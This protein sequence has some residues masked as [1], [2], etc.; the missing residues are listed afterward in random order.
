MKRL[1]LLAHPG[2][3]RAVGFAAAWRA[4][5][6]GEA[7]A[8]SWEQALAPGFDLGAEL[9]SAGSE[10]LRIETPAEHPEIERLLL[11]RGAA[12]A[13]AEGTDSQGVLTET[14]ARELP[15][16]DGRLRYQRQWYLGWRRALMEIAGACRVTGVKAMNDPAEIAVL[17]DK[18]A[19]R[20]ILFERGVPVPAAAGLA[21]GFDDL[22]AK[23]DAA[24][25]NRVFLKPCHGSSAAGV[26]A[27]SRRPGGGDWSAFTSAT[28]KDGGAIHNSKRP[29]RLARAAEIRATVDAVCRERALVERWFPKA[30]LG[31]RAFDLRILVIAGQAA[32]V[33]VRTSAS[34]ITNLHL[35]NRRGDLG[36]TRRAVGEKIWGEAMATAAAAAHGFPGCHYVGVDLMIGV[37]RRS[38]A[39]AEVNAF[40]D[41]LRRELWQGMN[42]WEA[43]VFRWR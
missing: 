19:T 33:A 11:A 30:T 24:G 34:P 43:E 29:R 18:L 4:A 7:H 21:L 22:V 37:A 28:L 9:D 6:H 5:G 35:R 31:G 1:A 3:R 36:E 14:A 10:V 8:I 26:M 27:I 41:D 2:S 32:Q 25:W 17:F 42:P 12:A 23:M 13:S 20:E 15:D 38:C 16:D 40:G 39:V